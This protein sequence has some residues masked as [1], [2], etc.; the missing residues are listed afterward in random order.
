MKNI[1]DFYIIVESDHRRKMAAARRQERE[2]RRARAEDTTA[3]GSTDTAGSNPDE[4]KLDPA[5]EDVSSPENSEEK[6]DSEQHE[7]DDSSE[8]DSS[9]LGRGSYGLVKKVYNTQDNQF[10]AM[11]IISKD[12]L[13]RGRAFGRQKSEGDAF[14]SVKREIAIMKKL[15]HP[16]IV[17]LMEVLCDEDNLYLIMEYAEGGPVMSVDLDDGEVEVSEGKWNIVTPALPLCLARKYFRDVLSGLEYL[18]HQSVIHRDIKP[19]NLL[20]GKDGRCMISDFGVSTLCEGDECLIAS[21]AGTG[22]FMSPEMVQSGSKNM[23]FGGAQ[24]DVWSLGVTLYYFVYGR[25]PWYARSVPEIYRMIVH[26]PLEFPA[27]NTKEGGQFAH[28]PPALKQLLRGMLDKNPKTR[29]TIA[30]INKCSWVSEEGSWCPVA[31]L[32]A[33][34]EGK[35]CAGYK[36]QPLVAQTVC[37]NDIAK[38]INVSNERPILITPAALQA[39]RSLFNKVK[40]RFATWKRDLKQK[41]NASKE[42]KRRKR[43]HAHFKY[44]LKLPVPEQLPV[45]PPAL[46]AIN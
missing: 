28:V 6:E 8:D 10:Y 15:D 31:A 16:N 9:I 3:S 41:C 30:Q 40:T 4:L 39:D 45:L 33:T 32:Q 42:E 27:D 34:E 38:A 44:I 1:S 13:S 23:G 22:V 46:P 26:D 18:H 12:L 19:E 25:L 11:K 29:L 5:A 17:H 20:V 7:D 36:N 37:K 21:T 43:M 14:D 35:R 2:Q 24:T